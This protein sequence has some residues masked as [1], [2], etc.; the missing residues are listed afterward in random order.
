LNPARLFAIVEE[1]RRREAESNWFE[2]KGNNTNPEM[3]AKTISGLANGARLADR[4]TAYIVWGVD[5]GPE[6]DLRGR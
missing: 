4:E 2:F 5:D 3:I 6:R 1:L